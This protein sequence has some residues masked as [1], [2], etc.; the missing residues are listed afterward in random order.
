MMHPLS[1]S[2]GPKGSTKQPARVVCRRH[3]EPAGGRHL[4]DHFPQAKHQFYSIIQGK[5]R[6][7]LIPKTNSD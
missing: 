5:V 2:C 6:A 1:R 3:R 7:R 4:G